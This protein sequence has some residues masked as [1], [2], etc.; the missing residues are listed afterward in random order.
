MIPSDTPTGRDNCGIVSVAML[1]GLTYAETERM[2]MD[3]FN[4]SDYTSI[5]D[6]M[7]VIH[8]IGLTVLEEKHYKYK[9]TLKNWLTTTY[10][11]AHDYHVS[12]TGHAVTIRQ[13]LLF[14]QV[15]TSGVPALQSPFTRKR[16]SAYIKLR[17]KKCFIEM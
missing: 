14:D 10:D 11:P 2:F 16:I 1:A 15:F 17:G 13:H 7:E 6:R 3:L 9:P 5:W 12:M 4:K 8:L